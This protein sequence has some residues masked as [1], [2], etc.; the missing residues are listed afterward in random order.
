[1]STLLSEYFQNANDDLKQLTQDQ[2]DDVLKRKKKCVDCKN[3]AVD[4][5]PEYQTLLI[6]C[7]RAP[8]VPNAICE[9]IKDLSWFP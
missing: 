4:K 6:R 7:S 2:L 1:M 8:A 3:L 9:W 5:L